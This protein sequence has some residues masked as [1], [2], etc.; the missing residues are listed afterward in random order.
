MQILKSLLPDKNILQ[1]ENCYI[2][3]EK[4]TVIVLVSSIQTSVKC[5][6]CNSPTHKIHGQGKFIVVL[7]DIDTGKL[8]GL[9]KERKQNDIENVMRKWGEVVLEQIEEVSMDTEGATK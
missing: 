2:D 3:E 7:V 4:A 5:P 9:V 8:I 6:V 1:L